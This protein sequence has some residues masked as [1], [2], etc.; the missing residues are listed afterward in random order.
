MKYSDP[1]NMLA[2]C[3]NKRK[4]GNYIFSVSLNRMLHFLSLEKKGKK[5]RDFSGQELIAYGFCSCWVTFWN[6]YLITPFIQESFAAPIKST[7]VN[8]KLICIVTSVLSASYCNP[9]CW[10]QLREAAWISPLTP[11]KGTT[12]PSELETCQKHNTH[13]YRQ[14]KK[15]KQKKDTQTTMKKRL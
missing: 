14:T 13:T 2:W 7:S 4:R 5:Y 8:P 15:N 6:S 9:F 3:T 12:Y 11:P 1:Q 10:T